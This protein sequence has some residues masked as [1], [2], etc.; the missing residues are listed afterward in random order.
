MDVVWTVTDF[1]GFVT[2]TCEEQRAREAALGYQ[3][4]DSTDTDFL[5][6][7]KF[8]DGVIVLYETYEPDESGR[9]ILAYSEFRPREERGSFQG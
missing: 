7:R 3:G 8:E 4:F 5:E 9:P 1:E 6:L 2:A